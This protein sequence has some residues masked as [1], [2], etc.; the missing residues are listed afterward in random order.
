MSRNGVLAEDQLHKH[1]SEA[2]V[3]SDC[4]ESASR[5]ARESLVG[6]LGQY[7]GGLNPGM[8]HPDMVEGQSE[9]S[10]MRQQQWARL[11]AKLR[12][13]FGEDYFQHHLAPLRVGLDENDSS[14]STIVLHGAIVS[15]AQVT[16]L[17]KRLLPLWQSEDS[18]VATIR[19][20][21]G[22]TSVANVPTTHHQRLDAKFCFEKFITSEPNEFAYAAARR[23]AESPEALY[24]PL[25]LFGCVG[26]GK[27][28]LMTAIARYRQQHFPQQRVLYLTAESF[29]RR[30]VQSI[31]RRD[32]MQFKDDFRQ[33]D[34]LL[35]D[36]IHFIAN[37]TSTQD[38]FF[39]TLNDLIEQGHQ[40][41]VASDRSPH[42][43]ADL[44][45]RV[46]SRLGA[47]LVAEIGTPDMA[48][49]TC[50][51]EAQANRARV[52]IPPEVI[53]FLAAHLPLSIREIEG[54]M[55]RLI[56]HQ[57]LIQRPMTLEMCRRILRD[58]LHQPR[59][60]VSIDAIQR[61]VAAYYR[62]KPEDMTSS[63]RARQVARPRQVAMYLSKHLTSRSLPE[64]GRQFGGRD[65]TTVM[66]AMKK[67]TVLCAESEEWVE[68]IRRLT[69]E[70]QQ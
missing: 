46:S 37:K 50:F 58:V 63:H 43:I 27:T 16:Q 11:M 36:D 5:P 30:F 32:V 2:K 34:V 4:H 28:H 12:S 70:L 31:K 21:T 66:H 10:P 53:D 67:I 55:N 15:A 64:I 62:I 52:G 26:L 45:S 40:V 3:N 23:V 44:E 49:R 48:L 19:V 1:L 6:T 20:L 51:L 69:Q 68:D 41:V 14:G 61:V 47:G 22:D 17:E 7:L 29:M 24:N 33:V 59:L 9:P 56:A 65:H 13:I 8:S 25:F 38:E 39:H 60:R 54:A 35:I 57:D 42:E 18:A